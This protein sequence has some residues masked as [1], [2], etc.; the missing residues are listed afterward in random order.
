FHAGQSIL[1]ASSNRPASIHAGKHI[2]ASRI[3]KPAPF[4]AGS[5]VPTGWTNPAVH[6]HVNK[7]IGI[8]DSS[9]S[10]SMTGNKEKLDDFVQ[11]KGGTV[12]FR[13]GD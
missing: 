7:D 5:S 2:S 1:A 8:V 12:T 4:S 11:V 6:P 3:N 10:R 13:G 9:C